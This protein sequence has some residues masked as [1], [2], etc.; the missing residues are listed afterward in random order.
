M[1]DGFV[2]AEKSQWR[3]P[4]FSRRRRRRDFWL[5]AAA[6]AAAATTAAAA[7]TT[8][9]AAA[10]LALLRFI[11]AQGTSVVLTP[12]EFAHGALGAIVFVDLHEAEAAR[13]AGFTI[14]DHTG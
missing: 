8:A 9:T 4:P 1:R 11:H 5:P 2:K 10:T 13:A 3:H 14:R 6:T 12:V 7:A